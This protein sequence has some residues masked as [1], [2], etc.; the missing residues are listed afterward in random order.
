M[1]EIKAGP[2]TIIDFDRELKQSA[3]GFIRQMVVTRSETSPN[4]VVQFEVLLA[5]SVPY[6]DVIQSPAEAAKKFWEVL[7]RQM[8]SLEKELGE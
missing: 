5:K 3:P 4:F 6:V 2:A 7:G 1:G 8:K